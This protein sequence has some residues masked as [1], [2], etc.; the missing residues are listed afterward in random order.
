MKRL[1]YLIFALIALVACKEDIDKSNRYVFTQHT[2]ATYLQSHEEYSDYMQM[3]E[4]VKI[5]PVTQ[6]TVWQLLGARGHFTCFAPTNEAVQR[7]LQTLVEKDLISSPT[8]DAFPDEQTRDSIRQ[9]IVMNSIIDGGDMQWYETNNFPLE[10]AE[11]EMTNMRDRKLSV[12]YGTDPDSI[13]INTTSLIDLKNRD[14]PCLNG[15]IHQ[16]HDVVVTND[17]SMAQLLKE[18]EEGKHSDYRVMATLI[19][20]CGMMDTLSKK[21][22]EAYEMA[23]LTGRIQDYDANGLAS[24]EDGTCYVPQHRK[25]GFTLFAEPDQLWEQTLG[26]PVDQITVDDVKAWVVAQGFYP[27]ASTDDDYSNVNNVLNQFVTYHLLPMRIPNNKLVI[28]NNER[29]YRVS[30][31]SAYTIPVMEHYTTMGKPRLLKI[32][33]SYETSVAARGGD[34]SGIY[35]NR[36]PVLDNKRTG[37]YHEQSCAPENE[38]VLVYDIAANLNDF[39]TE[40]GMIYPIDK[41]LAYSE[42]VRTALGTQRIRFDAMSMFPETMTNDIRQSG[43]LSPRTQNVAFPQDNVYKYLENLT[44]NDRTRTFCYFNARSKNWNNLQG[45]E[46]KG[47]GQYD[48][49]FKLPPVPRRSTYEIRYKVLANSDRGVCQIYFGTDPNNLPIAGIPM[50]LTIGGRLR[51]QVG[52]TSPSIAGWVEDIDDDGYNSDIDKQMRLNGFMKG[53]LYYWDG[54]ITSREQDWNVRRIIVRQ[55]MDPNQQYYLRFR[56]CIESERKEFYMDYIEYCPKEVYDNPMEPE[57]I[58]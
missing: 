50:D 2:V 4:R 56:S 6:S 32:Y 19:D 41:F 7:Y 14:I 9:V 49:T 29:G 34:N 35:L 55:T 10:S 16:M 27:D 53:P 26:K 58:W 43:I 23:Y 39:N 20:A 44:I 11:F 48:Y 54:S 40:N 5:S 45:D 1:Y 31:G 3:L 52:G 30:I 17:Q 13:Y 51:Y 21:R 38:G 37:T 24:T 47:V 33:Q 12:H 46:I 8:W 57:D 42:D 22:D 18:C 15:V 36:F 28:H 25:Y